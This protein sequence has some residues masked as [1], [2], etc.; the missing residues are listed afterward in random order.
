VKRKKLQLEGRKKGTTL[1][2]TLFTLGDRKSREGVL[3]KRVMPAE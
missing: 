2:E 3:K 1:K